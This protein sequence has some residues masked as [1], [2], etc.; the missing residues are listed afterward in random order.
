MTHAPYEQHLGEIDM[1][2]KNRNQLICA[3]M[4]DCLIKEGLDVLEDCQLPGYH[5][6]SMI[7]SN[8]VTMC[9][10]CSCDADN[11]YVDIRIATDKFTSE[12]GK[13]EIM[14]LVN[15]FNCHFDFY[16]LVLRPDFRSLLMQS[17]IFI[18][19]G[20][21]PFDK[22]TWLLRS[23]IRKGERMY[24]FF[25]NSTVGGTIVDLDDFALPSTINDLQYRKIR[26]NI[27]VVM[28]KLDLPIKEDAWVDNSVCFDV[29]FDHIADPMSTICIEV[30]DEPGCVSMAMTHH[31]EIPERKI[32]VILELMCHI[33]KLAMVDHVYYEPEMRRVIV[34]K[35]ILL[36]KGIL[37]VN[38]YECAMRTLIGNGCLYLGIVLEQLSSVESP[39]DL[40]SRMFTEHFEMQK[41]RQ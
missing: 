24:R 29:D 39:K 23:L 35:G 40:T 1:E 6:S 36:S 18:P 37:D 26:K 9:I 4:K 22:F 13:A 5:V 10:L 25:D 34:H 19:S 41:N 14:E 33:N 7:Q 30:V 2:T 20:N 38:E 27:E 32:P 21:L 17:A 11:S 12:L 3:Q 28:N 31:E 15:A 8:N 16:H